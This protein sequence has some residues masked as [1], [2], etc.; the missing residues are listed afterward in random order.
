MNLDRAD[1][2]LLLVVSRYL[3]DRQEGDP[4][5]GVVVVIVLPVDCGVSWVRMDYLGIPGVPVF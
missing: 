2:L 5:L 1:I 4:D 3:D